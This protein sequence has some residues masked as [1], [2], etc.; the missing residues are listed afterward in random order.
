[1]PADIWWGDILRAQA[2]LGDTPEQF[3]RITRLLG[4]APLA[5]GPDEPAAD[6]PVTYDPP[7]VGPAGPDRPADEATGPD[8]TGSPETATNIPVLEPV[9]SEPLS[10]AVAGGEVLGTSPAGPVHDFLPL[11]PPR[12]T[13]AVLQFLLS[14][15]VADGPPNVPAVLDA[16]AAG[17]PLDR[18]PREPQRTLRFGAELLVDLGESMRPFRRD[19]ASV[20]A[21]VRAV[22][23]SAATSV[24][25]FANAPGRGAGPG[26]PHTWHDY[27]PPPLGRHVLL[28]TDFG[29]G[30]HHRSRERSTPGE[31]LAFFDLL[32]RDGCR[33]VALVPF[34][35]HRWPVALSAACP[36]LMWDRSATA[37]R[38]HAVR[39]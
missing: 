30:R 23:G 36:M 11:L 28:L 27:R 20:V 38:A 3:T 13:S 7:P 17:R 34:P 8:D 19:Q 10:G 12:S 35:P 25:Y 1:M 16:I 5:R 6:T 37:G 21:Q 22:V 31:W 24:R 39:S 33:P 2:A 29:I 9:A 26:P 18:I 32:R 4:L 14:R 15:A